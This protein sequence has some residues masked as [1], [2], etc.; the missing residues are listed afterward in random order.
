MNVVINATP[1]YAP[2]EPITLS[3][4]EAQT[5]ITDLSGEAEII[6]AFIKAVR[7]RA[8]A[9]TRRALVIQSKIKVLD[10]FPLGREIIELSDPPLRSV[11]AIT[12]VDTDGVTQTLSPSTYRVVFDKC[13]P[14]QPSCI[15]PMNGQNW[16][17]A[18]NDK[19]V[20]EIVY[21]CGYE[22]MDVPAPI[23]QWM[24]LNVATLYEN[25]ELIAIGNRFSMVE[26]STLADPLLEN[27]RVYKF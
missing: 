18:L 9:I 10:A 23:K 11:E 7:L 26:L 3:D 2:V 24:L 27:Y 19:A 5:R 1:A 22:S 14:V 16:P 15:I 6:E 25:R 17:V 20:V 12:Y 13:D 4:V 8:E 21:T